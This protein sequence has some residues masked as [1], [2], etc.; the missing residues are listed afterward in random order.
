MCVCAVERI[1]AG[2]FAFERGGEGC[3]IGMILF[4]GWGR[5]RGAVLDR[6]M[7]GWMDRWR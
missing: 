2:E 7:D 1:S 3:G 5:G 4:V 6:W